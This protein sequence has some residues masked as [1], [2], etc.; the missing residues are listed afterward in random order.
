MSYRIATSDSFTGQY[1]DKAAMIGAMLGR[2][3]IEAHSCGWE[4]TVL[5]DVQW[6]PGKAGAPDEAII[7]LD[8]GLG[9]VTIDD[10]REFLRE[11][12]KGKAA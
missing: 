1:R 10:V 7:A 5:Q 12:A 9:D 8:R 4:G 2:I 6:T 3:K 11:Q